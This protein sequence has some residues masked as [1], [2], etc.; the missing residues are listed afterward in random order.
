MNTEL[1]LLHPY[2]FE[3]LGNLLKGLN[4]AC[5][6]KTDFFVDWRA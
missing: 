2:P 4:A 6:V 3:K 1:S 5:T